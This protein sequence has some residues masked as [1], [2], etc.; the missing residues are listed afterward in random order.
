MNVRGRFRGQRT[1]SA[2]PLA[3]ARLSTG[4]PV[5]EVSALSD[6]DP[7]PIVQVEV[8]DGFD[9]TGEDGGLRYIQPLRLGHARLLA[10]VLR[11]TARLADP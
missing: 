8:Y 4:A 2:S 1:A 11:S 7:V 9:D 3:L 5:P 10:A 6:P